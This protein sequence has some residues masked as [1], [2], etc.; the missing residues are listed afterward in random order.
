MYSVLIAAHATAATVA[1][2]ATAGGRRARWFAVY[3]ASLIAM[4]VLLVA[5]IAVDL[6][7]RDLAQHLVSGGLVLLGGIMLRHA[8]LARRVRR[9][10]AIRFVEHVGFTVVGLIDALVVVALFNA[11]TPGWAAAIVG[12]VIAVA[13]HVAIAAVRRR[14]PPGDGVGL[15]RARRHGAMT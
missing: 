13:G 11:G 14:T 15:R 7:G 8:E 6:P 5:A 10:D 1:L 2:A 12:V 3:D 9:T 4:L